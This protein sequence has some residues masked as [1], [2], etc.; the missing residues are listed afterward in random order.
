MNIFQNITLI[1][2]DLSKQIELENPDSEQQINFIGRL[3]KDAT[4]SF[5]IE[6]FILD[7]ILQL[8]FDMYKNGNSK[9]C[10]RIK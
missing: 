2:I 4:M 7:K 6:K 5:I 8:L 9:D 1:A 3:E 10:K